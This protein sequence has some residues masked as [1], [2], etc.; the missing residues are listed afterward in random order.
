VVVQQWSRGDS[1]VKL[2]WNSWH[3][4][5]DISGLPTRV[6]CAERLIPLYRWF[7]EVE[8]WGDVIVLETCVEFAWN[9]VKGVPFEDAKLAATV[10]ECEAVIP[11]MDDFSL[12]SRI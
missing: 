2:F 4:Y 3:R 11:D 8:S 7:Q 6:A 9:W 1:S 5:R 12:I 10:R